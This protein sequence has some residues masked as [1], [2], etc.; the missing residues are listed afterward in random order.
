M[1]LNINVDTN[2]SM[3]TDTSMSV[4]TDTSTDTN[5][6]T[7][8]NTS[9]DIRVMVVEDEPPILR[10]IASLIQKCDNGFSVCNTAKNG[11]EAELYL[12][13]AP[14]DVVFTD[15]RM[16]LMDGLALM[17][18]VHKDF[19]DV[20]IVV[21]SGYQDFE[22]AKHA[23]RNSA[24]DYLLKPIT[25]DAMSDILESLKAAYRQRGLRAKAEF[26]ANLHAS[27]ED[28]PKA[29][30]LT[31][32][33]KKYLDESYRKSITSE[34]LSRQF[35]Y[36]PSYIC[37]VFRRSFGVS[38]ATYVTKLRIGEAKALLRKRPDL[39]VK[40]IAFLVGFKDQYHFSKTFKKEEGVWPTDYR[41]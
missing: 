23:I 16:P 9:T 39:L 15:I 32:D 1:N 36:V 3:S 25:K 12:R 20:F 30:D 21:L 26:L 37:R 4:C 8:T 19:P 35:G 31:S 41:G 14:V 10:T 11:V 6:N 33:V 7:N 22:Y 5:T 40:E 38:P 13:N 34:D 2:T 17:E 27:I 28:A 24:F 18:I 29:H